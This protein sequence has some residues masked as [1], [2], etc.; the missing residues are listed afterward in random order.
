MSHSLQLTV[1]VQV[2]ASTWAAGLQAAIDEAIC[3]YLAKPD[4]PFLLSATAE[5]SVVVRSEDDV[6]WIVNDL[7]ELGVKIGNRFFFLYEGSSLE[8][9][10]YPPL[11]ADEGSAGQPKRYRPVGD[12]EFGETCGQGQAWGAAQ[13]I[14]KLLPEFGGW[15]D[16]PL[17]PLDREDI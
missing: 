13:S 17:R 7:A 14:E 5:D 16:L 3:R 15:K 2:N 6:E 1:N 10:A 9:K 12:R 11:A 8:Y 4:A